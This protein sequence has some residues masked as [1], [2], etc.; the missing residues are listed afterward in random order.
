MTQDIKRVAQEPTIEVTATL[1]L[2]E[3]ELRA[4]ETLTHWRDELLIQYL[5][6]S[7]GPADAARIAPGIKSLLAMT[8]SDIRP[9]LRRADSARF[10]FK[11]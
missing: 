11:E 5:S 9:I 6:E 3:V 4:L 8:V 10:A 7:M 1:R 2:N